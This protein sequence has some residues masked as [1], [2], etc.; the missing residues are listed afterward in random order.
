M[1]NLKFTLLDKCTE[2]GT[3]EHNFYGYEK[4]KIIHF[5]YDGKGN[6]VV[7]ADDIT[8][9]I[10]DDTF[11]LLMFSGWYSNNFS[12]EA[13]N[14]STKQQKV[15]FVE[16]L[17][18][19]KMIAENSIFMMEVVGEVL[20]IP[21]DEVNDDTELTLAQV[22]D[23]IDICTLFITYLDL[24]VRLGWRKSCHVNTTKITRNGDTK[25]YIVLNES[26]FDD[27]HK[28]AKDFFED[29]VEIYSKYQIDGTAYFAIDNVY[30]LSLQFMESL[31]KLFG[32]HMA[33]EKPYGEE[34]KS[35]S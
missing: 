26:S 34:S 32:L 25:M 28:G 2:N 9:I 13:Q 18:D 3:G 11:R 6:H 35:E 24:Q 7:K 20:E 22:K 23:V 14:N 16:I 29:E 17:N 12:T 10:D 4:V 27:L 15:T 1:K 8:D 33:A 31:I 19:F 21:F 30:F 5:N